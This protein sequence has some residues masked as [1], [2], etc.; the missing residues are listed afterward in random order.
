M[1]GYACREVMWLVLPASVVTGIPLSLQQS[2][3]A[4]VISFL[5]SVVT[6]GGFVFPDNSPFW[7]RNCAL[8]VI[9]VITLLLTP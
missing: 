2:F 5:T 4:L 7:L 3:L 6:A 1:E 9:A 8:F